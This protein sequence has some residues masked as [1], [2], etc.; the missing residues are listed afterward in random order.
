MYSF[1]IVEDLNPF[2]YRA[3][4]FAQG[5]EYSIIYKLS[6][7]WIKEAL[8]WRIVLSIYSATHALKHPKRFYKVLILFT[9]ILAATI[10]MQQ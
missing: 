8:Y 9:R 4:S 1:S 10:Y 7:E 5:F 3:F 6:F 2:K